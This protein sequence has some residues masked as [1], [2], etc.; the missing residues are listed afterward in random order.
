MGALL[1][2]LL[3]EVATGL[4]PLVPVGPL[5]V[6]PAGAEPEGAGPVELPGTGKG[7]TLGTTGAGAGTVASVVGLTAGGA[8]AGTLGA[9]GAA[10]AGGAT[11]ETLGAIGATDAGGAAAGDDGVFGAGATAGDD[12]AIGAGEA[13]VGA[14][15]AGLAALVATG[16]TAGAVVFRSQHLHIKSMAGEEK[17]LVTRDTDTKSK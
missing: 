16:L 17:H 11:A 4:E 15:G 12:G 8:A 10:D 6:V 1:D 2:L 3:L 14:T 7:A 5:E 9:I 13:G